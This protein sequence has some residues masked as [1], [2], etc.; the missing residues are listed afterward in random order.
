MQLAELLQMETTQ[1]I[2]CQRLPHEAVIQLPVVNVIMA[3]YARELS[4]ELFR[5]LCL[6]IGR[7]I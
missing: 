2:D 7:L 4:K 6:K 1:G 3:R 5:S